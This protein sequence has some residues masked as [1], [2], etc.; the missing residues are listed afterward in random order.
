LLRWFWS[1][2]W[3]LTMLWSEFAPLSMHAKSHYLASLRVVA[4]HV[5]GHLFEL[6]TYKNQVSRFS[7][8]NWIF[9]MSSDEPETFTSIIKVAFFF[10][11]RSLPLWFRCGLGVEN[12]SVMEIFIAVGIQ[13]RSYSDLLTFVQR[14]TIKL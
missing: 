12:I 5:C 2:P 1:V 9:S 13:L 4:F 10:Q 14:I 6:A 7:C 8:L 11:C 3:H